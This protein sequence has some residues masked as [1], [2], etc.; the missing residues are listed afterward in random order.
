MKIYDKEKFIARIVAM[1]FAL[2]T[3]LLVVAA[4]TANST[5]EWVGY[6]LLAVATGWCTG[7]C[8]TYKASM[9]P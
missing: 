9:Q 1:C 4:I 5:Y 7:F 6:T 8:A 3:C 2:M